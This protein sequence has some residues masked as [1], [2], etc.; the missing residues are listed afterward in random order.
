MLG[1]VYHALGTAGVRRSSRSYPS[2]LPIVRAGEPRP[3]SRDPDRRSLKVLVSAYACAPNRG[4]EP[5]VG[6]HV[7]MQVAR[8]HETWV[9]T[10]T[11]N[12]DA[13]RRAM[14]EGGTAGRLRFIFLEPFGWR[15][16]LPTRRRPIPLAANIHYY[17]W[18]AIAFAKARSLHKR[19]GFDVVHHVTFVRYYSPS[20]LSLLPAPFIWGPV[21][22]GES[23][24]LSFWTGLGLRGLAYETLRAL[25][26]SLGEWDPFVRITARHSAVATATTPETAARLRKL[27]ARNV[28]LL[29]AAGVSTEEFPGG[30]PSAPPDGGPPFFLAV[31]RLVPWKGVHLALRGFALARPSD[32]IFRIVGTGAD[33][34]RLERLTRALGIEHSVEFTGELTRAEVRSLLRGCL[35]LVHTSLHDSGSTV[36]LEA[37]AVGKPVICLAVG[38]PATQVTSDTGFSIPAITP[39]QSVRGIADALS[40]VANDE[41]LRST[42]G[43]NAQHRVRDVFAWTERERTL[44]G[45]YERATK[46]TER[47]GDEDRCVY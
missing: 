9:L 19:L 47:A 16:D 29:S 30:D 18:Q 39:R 12:E 31:T 25:V 10:T 34:P 37:M 41:T 44:T 13:I 3:R 8:R 26:R 15:L 28:R 1:T 46:L 7:A 21:G 4:S 45:M 14:H 35:A 42:L 40:R 33:R 5:S 38:G 23:A 24:P 6:W 17:A 43:E 11:E 36:C 20:F 22:G 27:G 32:V 2:A